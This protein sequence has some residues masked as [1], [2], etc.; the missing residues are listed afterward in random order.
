M[1]SCQPPWPPTRPLVLVVDGHED[2]RALYAL[3]LSAMGFNVVAAQDGDD[4]CRRACETH[5][6][7]IV[8]DLPMPNHDGWQLLHDLKQDPRTRDIAVVAVTGHVQ[9][10]VRA[11]AERDGVAAFF[12]KPCLPN[13]LAS[14]LRQVLNGRIHARASSSGT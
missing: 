6:D 5:P 8:I 13:E 14:G 9:E 10:S 2:T 1:D 4:A 11:H 3:A 12:S 7:I